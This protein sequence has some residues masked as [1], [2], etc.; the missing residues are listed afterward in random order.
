MISSA[1][2]TQS[3]V[4]T[5]AERAAAYA[6]LYDVPIQELYRRYGAV[7]LRAREAFLVK[8]ETQ[9]SAGPARSVAGSH[10]GAEVG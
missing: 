8:R 2:S 9:A 7:L 1:L 3:S 6:D 5:R 10:A 4:L